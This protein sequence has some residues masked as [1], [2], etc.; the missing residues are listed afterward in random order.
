MFAAD[1]REAGERAL[2]NFGH[3]FGHAIEAGVGYGEWLH[4]EAGAA[5]VGMAGEV[6]GRRRGGPE[7]PRQ[8]NSSGVAPFHLA[9]GPR[10]SVCGDGCLAAGPG[11]G[12]ALSRIMCP[13]QQTKRRPWAPFR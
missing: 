11:G 2:L 12:P 7:E 8:E 1:E 4:G 5:G 13:R 10:R 3:T 6:F 9:A